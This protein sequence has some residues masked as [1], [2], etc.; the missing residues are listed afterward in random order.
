MLLDKVD[1]A[2]RVKLVRMRFSGTSLLGKQ[3]QIC[4]AEYLEIITR[5]SL[6]LFVRRGWTSDFVLKQTKRGF[7]MKFGTL[8]GVGK[9]GI[10]PPTEIP[11]MKKYGFLVNTLLQWFLAYTC[12]LD[13][14]IQLLGASPLDPHQGSASGPRSGT[15]VPS[16]L[17]LS[18]YETYFWL[19][20]FG[21]FEI[22]GTGDNHPHDSDHAECQRHW[23]CA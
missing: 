11:M 14:Y 4:F 19:C 6:K 9:G 23:C 22:G 10:C 13:S 8:R 16:P 12:I 1:D 7:L 20:P 2:C 21:P 17:V 5:F 18:P 3:G 15:S